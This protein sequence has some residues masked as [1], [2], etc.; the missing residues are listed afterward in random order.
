MLARRDT[1]NLLVL[2]WRKTRRARATVEDA[3]KSLL[4]DG[5]PRA[6]SKDF[7]DQ[8]CAAVFEHFYENYPQR[9]LN[10]YRQ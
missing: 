1:K 4:D 2:D 10:V 7:Y 3:I 9:D 8:K 6:Y 5:L